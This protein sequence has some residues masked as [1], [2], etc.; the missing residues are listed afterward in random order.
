MGHVFGTLILGLA[1]CCFPT[2]LSADVIAINSLN[3]TQPQVTASTG[4]VRLFLNGS[5]FYAAFNGLGEFDFGS[6]AGP[7]TA[8][9]S[10]ATRL[11]IWVD[12]YSWV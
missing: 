12:E 1:L 2:V 7:D 4:S 11:A 3:L 5:A 6:D 10:A 9:A 8:S